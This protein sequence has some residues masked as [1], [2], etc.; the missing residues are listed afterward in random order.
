MHISA[1][2]SSVGTDLPLDWIQAEVAALKVKPGPL[3]PILHS[4]RDRLGY[5]PEEAVPII[6]EGLQI[7]RAE[8]HG[9]I[10]F[11]HDFNTAPI[12]RHRLQIC[13]AEACQ[14]RGCRSLETH[15][16]AKLGIDYHQTTADGEFTLEPVYCLGNCA[17]GPSVRLDND[18]HGRVTAKRLDALLGQAA[19]VPLT[20]QPLAEEPE[21]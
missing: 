1:Q 20:L 13:R 9:V 4:I 12:G 15:A 16:K 14:A 7:T 19:T 21:S 10:S 6:A 3:L 2:D 5:I 17:T 11:Y 18:I 8:V